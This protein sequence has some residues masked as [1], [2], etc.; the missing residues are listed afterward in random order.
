ML[1]ED[2]RSI[3]LTTD[4]PL[5]ECR[6][7]DTQI[8]NPEDHVESLHQHRLSMFPIVARGAEF[9]RAYPPLVGAAPDNEITSICVGLCPRAAHLLVE[10][11]GDTISFTTPMVGKHI[12]II[13][14][15]GPNSYFCIFY[16]RYLYIVGVIHFHFKPSSKQD[17]PQLRP[18]EV[19][20]YQ[21]TS[22][23]W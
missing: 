5:S 23:I 15:S 10:L 2:F 16:I 20:Q 17:G 9:L 12:Q 6:T 14:K 18:R 21:H 19:H 1:I 13:S 8:F 3:P 7:W 4:I 11:V 22:N